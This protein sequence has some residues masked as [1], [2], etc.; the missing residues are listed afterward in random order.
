MS[1]AAAGLQHR[2]ALA[3]PAHR[4]VDLAKYQKGFV[5]LHIL[6]MMHGICL[7]IHLDRELEQKSLM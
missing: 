4:Y 5:A 7:T 1:P 6:W 2:I 3:D